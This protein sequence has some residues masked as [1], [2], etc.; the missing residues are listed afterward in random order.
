M[1]PEINSG[2]IHLV[3]CQQTSFHVGQLDGLW[4]CW[5]FLVLVDVNKHK[6][7]ALTGED[8]TLRCSKVRWNFSFVLL[9]FYQSP[10]NSRRLSGTL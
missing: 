4:P 5:F 10:G 1:S 9:D 8:V 6:F 7:P 2:Y 3:S